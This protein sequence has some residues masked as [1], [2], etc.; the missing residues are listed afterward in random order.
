MIAY[1]SRKGNNYVN[2]TIRNLPVGNT[3]IIA[4]YIKELT[5]GDLFEIEAVKT[6]PADYM[7]CTEVAKN[8]MKAKTRPEL[9]ALVNDMSRYDKV[10]LGYPNWCS[11]MPM[12]VYTFLESYD[13]TGKTICPFCTHE[14]SG[15]GNSERDIVGEC[16]GADVRKGLAIKGS[17]VNE[18]RQEVEKWIG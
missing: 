11:T 12:P 14:G 8:E 16:P 15:L 5:G 10:Y 4:G 3:E 7:E 18:A 6:Y 2:G 13:F 17:K 1:F 9:T